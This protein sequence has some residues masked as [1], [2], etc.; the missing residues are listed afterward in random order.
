MTESTSLVGRDDDGQDS[1]ENFSSLSH[2]V[3]LPNGTAFAHWLISKR[4]SRRPRRPLID[5]PLDRA[6][7][8]FTDSDDRHPRSR[9]RGA[10]FRASRFFPFRNPK[11]AHSK[12]CVTYDITR[13]SRPRA[14]LCGWPGGLVPGA[15]RDPRTSPSRRRCLLGTS[16][17]GIGYNAV[18]TEPCRFREKPR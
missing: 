6:A 14:G 10:N 8:P 5:E 11:T 2:R 1:T 9:N 12:E 15:T 18:N 3:E 17:A 4:A 13:G 16:P 7:P